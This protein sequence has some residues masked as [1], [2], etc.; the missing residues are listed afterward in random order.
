MNNIVTNFDQILDFA[1]SYGLPLVKKRAILR[2]YLQVK[3]LDLLYQER[4]SA[5]I[6]FV[7]G[8]SLRLLRGLDRF[9]EDLDFDLARVTRRETKE[10]V[11]KIHKR[12]I[13][14]N[15]A[16]D[17][18]QNFTPKRAHYELRFRDL[19]YELKITKNRGEKLMIKFD[20]E[21]F[22]QKQNREVILLKRYGFLVNA[23]T[24]PLDQILVQKLWA[25]LK[26]KQTLPR[27]AYDLVWLIAQGAKI[28]KGFTR[29]NSLPSDLVS[30]AEKKFSQERKKLQNLKLKLRP[31]LVDEN[32]VEK[33]ELL[34]R[35]LKGI[36]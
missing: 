22:W 16:V 36:D 12:L 35:V 9:S 11:A 23:V 8:T 24:L 34:P 13:Q 1:K 30:Q 6:F 29:K 4:V 21:T 7:G 27:D 25:Y 14:E 17:L 33:L 2:E 15:I 32:Y 18:Y 5:G 31:F 26:R 20:F 3:I 10:L 19:L 28:D